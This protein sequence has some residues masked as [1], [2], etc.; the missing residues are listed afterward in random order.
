[1][2]GPVYLVGMMASGKST[3]G[4]LLARRLGRPFLDLDQAVERRARM[5]VA[6][7]FATRG[8]RH[9]RRVE[10]LALKA[11]SK[12]SELVVATGGGAVIRAANRLLLKRGVVV[13][14][15]AR[16][17]KILARVPLEQLHA[18]PLLA[19]GPLA[20]LK[21]LRALRGPLYR[22]VAAVTQ[23][24]E[25]PRARVLSALLRRLKSLGVS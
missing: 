1:M 23:N 24:A 16:P 25:L 22:E 11:A 4:K 5:S 13:Y 12:R 17:A 6:R 21:K 3:I 7:V 10:A 20:A 9:F 2:R 8:E 18:R 19:K 15:R 14:L